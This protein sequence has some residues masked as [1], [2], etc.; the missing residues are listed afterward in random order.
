MI[1]RFTS[2]PDRNLD[3]FTRLRSDLGW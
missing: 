2:D 1:V 3:T